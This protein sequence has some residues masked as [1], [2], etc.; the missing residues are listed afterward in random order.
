MGAQGPEPSRWLSESMRGSGQSMCEPPMQDVPESG[1]L[2]GE[3]AP[4]ARWRPPPPAHPPGRPSRRFAVRTL[5]PEV[6]MSTLM[7]ES[8]VFVVLVAA[9]ELV[10]PTAHAQFAVVDVGAISQLITQA[11]TLEQQ[12][13]TTGDQ[14][15]VAQS[16]LRAMSGNR[17]M[18]R[19]LTG[20]P[21]NYL[22]TS[23]SDLQSV[24]EGQQSTF[25]GLAVSVANDATRNAVLS[26][27]QLAALPPRQGQ[28]IRD[29]RRMTALLQEAM[30]AALLTT[31]QRFGSLQ[32]LIGALPGATDPKATLDLQA[33][34]EAENAMLQNE[35][36]KLQT[37]Y[38][39]M[40]AEDQASRQQMHESTVAG[41]GSFGARF[42][43]HP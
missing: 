1:R 39:L 12:L 18:D 24:L 13:A 25:P 6:E 26:P 27:S 14:L 7:R 3:T 10:A 37:L 28:Q 20:A 23:W 41:H 43:P 35:Q 4:G 33:R 16:E 42:Q 30:R 21:R 11:Q 40:Q 9:A 38:E 34:I 5:K 36:T 32:Q 2:V 22:P 17:G 31:S 15:T 29:S 8:L 19:L